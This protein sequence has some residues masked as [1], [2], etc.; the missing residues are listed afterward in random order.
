MSHLPKVYEYLINIPLHV[1]ALLGCST[2]SIS[3]S[4]GTLVFFL[5][6]NPQS[7]PSGR[8][9]M[10]LLTQSQEGRCP[11]SVPWGGN[12]VWCHYLCSNATEQLPP[13][14]GAGR[15]RKTSAGTWCRRREASRSNREESH[16]HCF[17][18]NRAW[19]ASSC[20]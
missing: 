19:C 8:S 6:H 12:S 1:T 20:N 18:G 2:Q 9:F 17:Q 5:S 14:P 3:A 7:D 16:F 10:L 4:L 13:L 11:S 15:E